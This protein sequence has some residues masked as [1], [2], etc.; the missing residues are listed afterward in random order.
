MLKKKKWRSL[1]VEM[2]KMGVHSGSKMYR[3]SFF[4]ITHANP[5]I[6]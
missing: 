1:L 5:H 4:A 6:Y 3:V 2:L